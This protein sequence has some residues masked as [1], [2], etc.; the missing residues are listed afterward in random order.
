MWVLCYRGAFSAWDDVYAFKES[1][2]VTVQLGKVIDALYIAQNKPECIW[3]LEDL[4]LSCQE[5]WNGERKE[6]ESLLP[7]R[8]RDTW[9]TDE[10][11]SLGYAL[12][13]IMLHKPICYQTKAT[14]SSL[15]PGTFGG[16]TL[17]GVNDAVCPVL[18]LRSSQR[19][20]THLIYIRLG[21]RETLEDFHSFNK[22]FLST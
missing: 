3:L 18:I 17:R 14:G 16:A 6:G 2:Y 13:G 5:T 4:S 21:A 12:L 19:L 11:K 7:Q 15:Y 9:R 22:C 10:I 8:G 1:F 20:L